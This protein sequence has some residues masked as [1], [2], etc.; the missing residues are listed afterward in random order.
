MRAVLPA[1]AGETVVGIC[2]LRLRRSCGSPVPQGT[3]PK[4]YEKAWD[5]GQ[6]VAS[7][8]APA[9]G[10]RFRLNEGQSGMGGRRR[11]LPPRSHPQAVHEVLNRC[12]RQS[13]EKLVDD[14]ALNDREHGRDRLN[15]EHC[16]YP[17]ARINIDLC[18][19][20]CTG[21]LPHYSIQG[22]GKLLRRTRPGCPEVED[23][24]DLE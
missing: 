14:D 2:A 9:K 8:W 23:H 7:S 19:V 20:Y 3:G 13:T 17:R 15:S 5:W 10:A 11:R 24:G 18:E 16:A 21:R 6:L 4:T 12:L 22:K 1:Q